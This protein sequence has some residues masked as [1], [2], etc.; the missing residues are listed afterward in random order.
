MSKQSGE[1]LPLLTSVAVVCRQFPDV[2]AQAQVVRCI[3]A[4]VDVSQDCKPWDACKCLGLAKRVCAR[5]H[6]DKED[7]VDGFCTAAY[8]GNLDVMEWLCVMANAEGVQTMDLVNMQDC[9][10]FS[11]LY[12]AAEPGHI[13]AITWLL[14]RGAH[15]DSRE[16]GGGTTALLAAAGGGHLPVIEL[17]LSR[18]ASIEASDDLGR[19][20]LHEAVPSG[21][22]RLL[23]WVLERRAL[24]ET[25][26][27][28]KAVPPCTALFFGSVMKRN[29]SLLCTGS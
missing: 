14:D 24:F 21:E 11:P 2:A 12:S 9:G 18:G 7:I 25:P 28:S 16:G 8:C 27:T 5:T 19:S 10:G 3:E 15:V 1:E 17:L 22:L 29:I 6:W 4:F 26:E 23:Q 20:L 13:P